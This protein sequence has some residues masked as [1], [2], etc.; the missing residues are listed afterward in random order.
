ML[1]KKVVEPYASA[2][3]KIA[4]DTETIDYV[5]SD[6]QNLLKI[7]KSNNELKNYLKNPIYSKQ[8][9]KNILKKLT[10]S[11][12][13][14]TV[15]FIM[16]LVDRSRIFL[17]QEIAEKYLELVFKLA[18]IKIIHLISAFSLTSKQ[19]TE[20]I[21]QL[22]NYTKTKEIK[23]EKSIDKNLLG[24]FKIQIDSSIID[25]SLKGQ[26]GQLAN[27]LETKLF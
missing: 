15:R 4:V 23:L 27:Q 2:L 1:I 24:G 19:E 16:L 6:I 18:N 20:I 12:N 22:K 11:K 13:L 26:L 21:E 9:K 14:N 17:F 8:S 7:F 25:L 3:I 5:T 10:E